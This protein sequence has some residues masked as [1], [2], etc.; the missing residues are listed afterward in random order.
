MGG[1][2]VLVHCIAGISRASTI[3]LAYLL[4]V[5][6]L[7]LRVLMAALRQ[8]RSE[9]NPN[10]GFLEQL[11]AF[12]ASDARAAAAAASGSAHERARTA[13]EDEA[14][15]LQLASGQ[16]PD[17]SLAALQS[18]TVLWMHGKRGDRHRVLVQPR[19]TACGT[20]SAVRAAPS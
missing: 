17:T 10:A 7:E 9:A 6:Q 18:R 1:G 5:T 15:L 3:V 19:S 4:A 14:Y 20:L 16:N 8:A 2:N 13:N 12:A 11:E